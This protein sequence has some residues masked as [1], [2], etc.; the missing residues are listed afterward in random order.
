MALGLARRVH[1]L[2]RGA[3]V[4]LGLL[5]LRLHG[6]RAAR[7]L[8]GAAR[9]RKVARVSI[10]ALVVAGE[11]RGVR[12]R[13]L[14]ARQ[15]R[16]GALGAVRSGLAG[17]ARLLAFGALE[18]AGRALVARG[19]ASVGLD[20]AGAAPGLLGAAR[21]REV[22][23]VRTWERASERE[24]S[25]FDKANHNAANRLICIGRR[26]KPI[27]TCAVG[28]GAKVGHVGVGALAARQ[29]R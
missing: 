26:H 13:A 7:R 15:R 20:G 9:R 6:T 28:S 21:R 17:D 10:D 12:V 5:S 18:R 2:A 11:V 27:R 3:V 8:L 24:R 22:A 25:E 16:A 19:L 14:R 29:R 4:T 1:E 23:R